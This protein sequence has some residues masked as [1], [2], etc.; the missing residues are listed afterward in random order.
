MR[1]T[2]LLRVDTSGFGVQDMRK[3]L[4][5]VTSAM[6]SKPSQYEIRIWQL[7]R[8]ERAHLHEVY[9]SRDYPNHSGFDSQAQHLRK[10]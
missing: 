7:D 4:Q 1:A 6:N 3:A 2:A 10:P 8:S 9:L 5:N